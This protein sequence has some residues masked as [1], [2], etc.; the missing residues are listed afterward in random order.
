MIKNIFFILLTATVLCNYAAAQD[1]QDSLKNSKFY[2]V[3]KSG[4][5]TTNPDSAEY[6]RII[7]PDGGDSKLFQ[8]EEV[9]RNGKTK[10]KCKS[11]TP[12]FQYKIQGLYVEYYPNGN[13]E[14][15]ATY[16]K[17]ILSGSQFVNFPNGNLYYSSSY[18]TAKKE[19]IVNEVQ[20]STGTV[21]AENGNGTWVRY[22]GGY[23][24]ILDQG[25]IHNGVRDGEW[26]GRVN[27]TVTYVCTYSNGVSI[28]GTS[29]E[30]SG[31]VNHFTKDAIEPTFPGGINAFY[32]LLASTVRY[33]KQAKRNYVQGKVFLSFV[34]EKDGSLNDMRVIRGIGYGCDEEALRALKTSPAWIPGYQYGIPVRVQYSIPISFTLQM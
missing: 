9:Y 25:P 21:Q 32:Q 12:D 23:K 18:D 26:K 7:T 27:D 20:D 19:L 15:K 2:Y 14:A 17:G 11:L 10:M 24:H 8:V 29:Y 28:S 30:K 33:P 13:M 34:V 6:T 16:D 3:K 22:W 31:K 5:L 1:D 4:Q